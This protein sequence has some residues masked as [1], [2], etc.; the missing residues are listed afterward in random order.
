VCGDRDLDPQPLADRLP[1]GRALVVTGDHLSAV[2]DP[3]LA[4]AIVA[5]LEDRA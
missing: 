2:A 3:A 4:S 5:F 1:D